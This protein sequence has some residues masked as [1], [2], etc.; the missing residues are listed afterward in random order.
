MQTHV[1]LFFFNMFHWIFMAVHW[2][3]LVAVND[4]YSLVAVCGLLFAVASLVAEHGL[5]STWIQ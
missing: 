4:I 5:W 1:I 2:L 3:P